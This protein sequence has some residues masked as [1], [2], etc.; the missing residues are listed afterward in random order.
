MA[1]PRLQARGALLVGFDP[2]QRF[3]ALLR[4]R[5]GHLALFFHDASGGGD[6]VAVALR[7]AAKQPQPSLRLAAAACMAPHPSGGVALSTS[8]LLEEMRYMGQGLVL[9]AFSVER[10]SAERQ[11]QQWQS[12]EKAKRDQVKSP[13]QGQRAGGESGDSAGAA[14]KVRRRGAEGD[15]GQGAAGKRR[16]TAAAADV[17][18][19]A[20][21]ED[22]EVGGDGQAEGVRSAVAERRRSEATTGK[23]AAFAAGRKAQAA[24]GGAGKRAMVDAAAEALKVQAK[25]AKS[26]MPVKAAAASGK[27]ATA[28]GRTAEASDKPPAATAAAA[29]FQPASRFM[30]RKAGF[31][32]GKGLEGLG[33][34]RD[35]TPKAI[36][37]VRHAGGVGGGGGGKN[38]GAGGRGARPQ[39]PRHGGKGVL[40]KGSWG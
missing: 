33:Y 40:G 12:A 3:V 9:R 22:D 6:L 31:Y 14:G 13:K 27:A 28:P 16:R 4:R 32:F 2:A 18:A 23:A 11:P 25:A 7:P 19:G 8:E 1:R 29:A 30:G 38:G 34:H 10:A 20:W 39:Q 37:G 17:A 24:P 35:A 21:G 5:F 36:V 15:R 26:A